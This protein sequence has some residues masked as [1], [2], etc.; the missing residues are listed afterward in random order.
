VFLQ[1]AIDNAIIGHL[2][3]RDGESSSQAP[4]IQSSFTNYPSPMDRIFQNMD[5]SAGFGAIFYQM[6]PLMG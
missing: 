2:Q 3:E 1:E 4:R 5:L 6:G